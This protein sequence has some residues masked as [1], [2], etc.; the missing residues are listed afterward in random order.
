[1]TDTR[2]AQMGQCSPGAK[3]IVASLAMA[4]ISQQMCFLKNRIQRFV[5]CGHCLQRVDIGI[6]SAPYRRVTSEISKG[7]HLCTPIR[8][9]DRL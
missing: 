8:R 4:Q 1:M 2:A 5:L 3:T 6:L 7:R 9:I